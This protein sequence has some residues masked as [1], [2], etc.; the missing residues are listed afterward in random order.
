MLAL[1]MKPF[2]NAQPDPI[3][4]RRRVPGFEFARRDPPIGFDAS[5]ARIIG[6]YT[7]SGGPFFDDY[8][9]VVVC[10]NPVETLIWPM[11]CSSHVRRALSRVLGCELRTGLANRTDFASRVMWPP[12]LMENPLFDFHPIKRKGLMGRVKDYF[13]PLVAHELT[14]ELRRCLEGG[15]GENP[16]R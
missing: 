16:K 10:E 1:S 15:A 4:P 12:P 9:L 13:L 5:R 7:T 8:F 6:E 2:D 11:E 14:L 3:E